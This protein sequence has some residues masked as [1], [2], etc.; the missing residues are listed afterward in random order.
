MYFLKNI[1][2]KVIYYVIPKD[3]CQYSLFTQLI[4][5]Y[6]LGWIIISSVQ[7][8]SP[9][10]LFV[11]SWTTARQASLSITNYQVHS[12]PCPSSQWCHPS[13]PL[14]SP[15]PLAFDLSQHQSLFKWVSSSHQV[16]KVLE[17]HLQHQ[18]F[19][20]TPKTDIL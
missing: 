16:A 17:F 2:Q 12:N 3:L 5:L 10:Q 7:L 19:Q 13:H 1:S 20:W 14:S 9:V 8:L 18:S 4:R 15:S 11:T 6:L